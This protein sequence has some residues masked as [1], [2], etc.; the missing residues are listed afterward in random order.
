MYV[1][2]INFLKAEFALQRTVCKGGD[3]APPSTAYPRDELQCS[4]VS[5]KFR[6]I[7]LYLVL[8]F[9]KCAR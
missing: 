1:L 6:G 8:F 7:L 9:V 3:E 4:S 5:I 2:I